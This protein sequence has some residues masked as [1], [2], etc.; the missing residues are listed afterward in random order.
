MS[1]SAVL[2]LTMLCLVPCAGAWPD[3]AADAPDPASLPEWAQITA[4]TI[5]PD[6][7]AAMSASAHQFVELLKAG[8]R[9]GAFAI[10]APD[11]VACRL[12]QSLNP[13]SRQL[14]EVISVGEPLLDSPD[15]AEIE[16]HARWQEPGVGA[17]PGR[18]YSGFTTLY[19]R[20]AD[21]Q[22]LIHLGGGPVDGGSLPIT[23]VTS[24]LPWWLWT[25]LPP[26]NPQYQEA[27]RGSLAAFVGGSGPA[28]EALWNQITGWWAAQIQRY[29][30][31]DAIGDRSPRSYFV[32]FSGDSAVVGRTLAFRRGEVRTRVTYR[33]RLVTNPPLPDGRAPF[34][35]WAIAD[36]CAFCLEPP[37]TA[38]PAH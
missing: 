7:A 31:Y 11:S 3:T 20:L 6:G 16:V 23:P 35:K 28:T 14:L 18:L 33:F 34:W 13:S 5:P 17:N 32:G 9:E 26:G 10:F 19:F 25:R 36:A 15:A 29:G 8:N 4:Q 22:P 30:D 24:L 27:R 38:P 12:A 1:K 21:E 2:A 37:S